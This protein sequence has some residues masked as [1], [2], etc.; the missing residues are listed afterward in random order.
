MQIAYH[1]RKHGIRPHPYETK[2]MIH[3]RSK[4]MWFGYLLAGFLLLS[5]GSTQ[6]WAQQPVLQPIQVIE[7]P[8]GVLTAAGIAGSA[9]GRYL[10]VTDQDE[11]ALLVLARTADTGALQF[12]ELQ[13]NFYSGI[14]VDVALSPDDAYVYVTQTSPNYAENNLAIFARNATTG[15]LTAV[16]GPAFNGAMR[17]PVD[18]AISP[19]GGSLYVAA[20]SDNAVAIF[21]RN[22]T[23][24]ALTYRESLIDE[25]NGITAFS[26]MKSLAISPDSAYVYAAAFGDGAI[27][28]FARTAAT[29]ALS[30]VEVVQEGV[31]GISGLG[32]LQSIHLSADGS[33]LFAVS[34]ASALTVFQRNAN[35]GKLTFQQQLRDGE[36]G[37]TGLM[38]RKALAVSHNGANV[39][40]Y[41]KDYTTPT[42]V[43]TVARFQR[44]TTNGVLTFATVYT[45]T[46]AASFS[47]PQELFL[48][49]DGQQLYTS[50]VDGLGRA[51]GDLTTGALTP[52]PTYT[53]M[54]PITRTATT[55]PF[56]F[57]GPVLSPDG[58]QLYVPGSGESIASA[59]DETLSIFQRDATTGK[60]S[61][62]Q[63]IH[64]QERPN[65]LHSAVAVT[66]SPDGNFVYATGY[67]SKIARY[68]RDNATGRLTYLGVDVYENE[69]PSLSS[70]RPLLMPADGKHLYVGS[71]QYHA[72]T[73]AD[74]AITVLAR[75]KTSGELTLVEVKP[76]NLLPVPDFDSV[77][78]LAFSPEGTHLYATNYVSH[79]LTLLERN[80]TTGQLT[81]IKSYYDNV[82]G[83]DG[84]NQA[85]G[86]AVS[87]D[88][89]FLYVTGE[90]GS[91][92]LFQRNL[93][94]GILS[95][96][97][98]YKADIMMSSIQI[99]PDGAWLYTT[100]WGYLIPT[101]PQGGSQ[102]A[103][104]VFA[105][106][107]QTGELTFVEKHEDE[108]SS[109][110]SLNG[111]SGL[112]VSPDGTFV[113]VTSSFDDA[114]TVFRRVVPVA[115]PTATVMNSPTATSTAASPTV[116]AT[117]TA[118]PTATATP[119]PTST[120]IPI[121]PTGTVTPTP[122]TVRLYLP[123]IRK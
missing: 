48:P 4:F 81:L 83:I 74:A 62:I 95:Y 98:T 19:D 115:T 78:G 37:V 28:V 103:V 17:N 31:N 104:T 29:G 33:Q 16:T 99:S 71:T 109:I 67:W 90:R 92:T 111:V 97:K 45:E 15:R 12:V 7:A 122:T 25:Q 66:V 52:Q 68:A 14:P 70:F 114:V 10:Y 43:T 34:G 22:P 55:D 120:V 94:S 50:H 85:S 91:I 96:V 6:S 108:V 1:F 8:F 26:S 113:Y 112:Q 123:N 51:N 60:L 82:D 119:T 87:T 44:N 40:V 65:P 46:Q 3:L 32:D 102:S 77:G 79:S 11:R 100:G 73:A 61:A 42:A 41:T 80:P 121:S 53:L 117:P 18:L 24:G 107:P 57:A 38:G 75:N 9:D 21:Q 56:S 35:S 88:G 101:D 36:G 69:I 72:N 64:D 30:L 49:A 106:N 105:R 47:D 27:N 58:Q 2:D 59:N 118:T 5:L 13:N 63:V 23:T 93:T 20:Y 54:F 76:I 84:L 39:Y 89:A 86:L 116:T 110:T